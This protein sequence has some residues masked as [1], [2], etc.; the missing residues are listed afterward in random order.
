MSRNLI[1]ITL[2]LTL[3]LTKAQLKFL[4]K[5]IGKD[6]NSGTVLGTSDLN[7]DLLPDL[8]IIHNSVELWLGLNTGTEEFIWTLLDHKLD[9][10]PWSVN[11]VDIDQ[12]KLND[13]IIAGEAFGI[14]SYSQIQKGVFV[15]IIV[16]STKYYSQA[17]SFADIDKNSYPD[18]FVCG[19]FEFSKYYKNTNGQFSLDTSKIDLTIDEKDSDIGNYGSIW[20]DIDNDGDQD[21]YVSRCRPDVSNPTDRRRRNLFF[22]NNN[23]SFV[24]D[25]DA[26][27]ITV[28][29]QTWVSEIGDLDNDGLQDLVVLNHYTPSLIFKQTA[30][31]K[32]V[33]LTSQSGFNYN[34]NGMQL[35]MRDFD[36]DMDLDMLIVGEKNE[37]WL[38]QGNMKFTNS[39]TEFLS[40]IINS[41]AL[42]DFNV[43]GS[44][45]FL[46]SFGDFINI[47]NIIRNR[48]F[49][50]E[51]SK[52]HFMGFNLEG[53]PSNFNA[54]GAI[55]RVYLNGSFQMR[56]VRSG[57]S[58]GVANAYQVHFGLG[59]S[60]FVDSVVIN[61]PNG[62]ISRMN[63][64]IGDQYYLVTEE[65]CISTNAK[66]NTSARNYICSGDLLVISSLK[67]YNQLRWNNG[68][69]NSSII[70]S[71]SG[72]YYFE[73]KDS[74]SCKVISNPTYVILNPQESARLNYSDQQI[75]CYNDEITLSTQ[76]F[77]A[78]QWNNSINSSLLKVNQSGQYFA[79]VK[80]S[81]SEFYSDTISIN[82]VDNVNTPAIQD[83]SIQLPSSL[84]LKTDDVN[85]RWYN[86]PSSTFVIHQGSDFQTPIINS[87]TDYWLERF[88]NTSY[89]GILQGYPRASFDL[90]AFHIQ[91][92]N[93]GMYF[94]VHHDC[95]LDTFKV[96]TDRVGL[97]KFILKDN[98]NN[99]IDSI[100]VNLKRGENIITPGFIL[101]TSI[102]K[103]FLTTDSSLN[104]KNFLNIS[105]WLIRS[106]R[107]VHYPIEGN[108]L[109]FLHSESGE[110]EYH[111]F[112]Y[113]KVRK[114][115]QECTSQRVPLR[116]RL[117]NMVDNTAPQQANIF[118][119][120]KEILVNNNNQFYNLSVF[121]SSGSQILAIRN[122][123]A[124]KI[125]LNHLL[126]GI[127]FAH[128]T[129]RTN[130]STIL[131]I[132]IIY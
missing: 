63:N 123:N 107:D 91:T 62:L 69:A 98:L 105:P 126:P 45:D 22:H 55:I 57:E 92:L 72:I 31:H 41:C 88:K 42:A 96:F 64:L 124:L 53:Q 54:I 109:T 129:S 86:S 46:A 67:N 6:L 44:I 79:K 35:V 87:T 28:L 95:I 3:G 27:N 116:I 97:R 77:N 99:K 93:G 9:G 112:Y 15:K 30:D 33:D 21:L 111:Y 12:N 13:I 128:Y 60:T 10:I 83:T 75:F 5:E 36:N 130:N 48:I 4:P 85:T 82:I 103:Y 25:A 121:N 32:F 29:D 23:G 39:N 18:V 90:N 80:G 20:S 59:K 119:V 40:S 101:N 122:T 43:D 70:V 78:I 114:L 117:I 84:L 65:G 94:K 120:D 16:D 68:S 102:P 7:G 131:K 110:A 113:C 125:S 47:P 100:E 66:L 71:N 76:P 19:E 118:V 115:D 34:G 106:D 127:Y 132:P 56:E 2:F 58:F 11:I 49:F 8:V 26:R 37:I 74:N 17:V 24:E 38:N 52:N 73:A 14:Q 50:A 61:W 1:L 104:R 108:L 81:C 51:K 89:D